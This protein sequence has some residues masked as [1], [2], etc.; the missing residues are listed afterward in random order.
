MPRRACLALALASKRAQS[1]C[2]LRCPAAGVCPQED[3]TKS[4]TYMKLQSSIRATKRRIMA[5]GKGGLAGAAAKL[6]SEGGAG[7]AL[8]RVSATNVAG[9]GV[10]R[11]RFG[12]L[13]ATPA[14]FVAAETV[15]CAAPTL[16]RPGDVVDVRVALDGVNFGTTTATY[17]YVALP[18]LEGLSPSVGWRTGGFGVDL[19]APGVGALHVADCGCVFGRTKVDAA[20]VGAKG[21]TWPGGAV[22]AGTGGWF[23]S[24]AAV[25]DV[26]MSPLT[27]VVV[28]LGTPPRLA[29]SNSSSACSC[30]LRLTSSDSCVSVSGETSPSPW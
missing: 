27:G 9:P 17:E 18:E 19:R 14:T 12:D 21:K 24:G 15:D 5:A 26:A 28:T 25:A 6:P 16:G 11:C 29:L 4:A 3:K 7:G 13:P 30:A 1:C 10:L 22:G 2:H 20:V 23:A 8:V